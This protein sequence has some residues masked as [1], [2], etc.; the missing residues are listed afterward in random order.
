VGLFFSQTTK[1]AVIAAKEKRAQQ[2]RQEE[3]DSLKSDVLVIPP[4]AVQPTPLSRDE[5]NTQ[6]L[7]PAAH[8]SAR[9]PLH[10]HIDCSGCSNVSTN[11]SSASTSPYPPPNLHQPLAAA[12][13][14]RRTARPPLHRGS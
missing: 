5:R 11:L 14:S 1:E 4:D 7:L 2:Q 10:V 13:L 8:A 3:N 12:A 6:V 9:A